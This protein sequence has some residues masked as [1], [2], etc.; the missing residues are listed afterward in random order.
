MR[1]SEAHAAAAAP[2]SPWK[3]LNEGFLPQNP[4]LW[5]R[6]PPTQPPQPQQTPFCPFFA[7]KAPWDEGP[8]SSAQRAASPGTARTHFSPFFDPK[9]Q[10]VAQRIGCWVTL[11]VSTGWRKGRVGEKGWKRAKIG[12][13]KGG[14][15]EKW[16]RNRPAKRKHLV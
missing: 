2:Q 14:K 7:P 1:G 11:R 4:E 9:K 16:G 5:E 13:K 10:R 6:C 12:R 3:C 8:K 15:G